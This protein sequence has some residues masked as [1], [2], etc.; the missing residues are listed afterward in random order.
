MSTPNW[1]RDSAL[2]SMKHLLRGCYKLYRQGAATYAEEQGERTDTREA[3]AETMP[4]RETKSRAVS[5]QDSFPVPG[6]HETWIPEHISLSLSLPLSLSLSL[7]LS[8][9]NIYSPFLLEQVCTCIQ[10]NPVLASKRILTE[11]ITNS[12]VSLWSFIFFPSYFVDV[13]K[14]ILLE[15][16]EPSQE[17]VKW[18]YGRFKIWQ[19]GPGL[20]PALAI[21][22]SYVWMI[23]IACKIYNCLLYALKKFGLR[24]SEECCQ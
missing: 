14:W 17:R 9:L 18:E 7:S 3:K 22:L 23:S 10:N 11:M 15:S 6:L 20:M 1:A 24:S 12:E 5:T 19:I 13:K 16:H 8:S 4:L 21:I 2:S